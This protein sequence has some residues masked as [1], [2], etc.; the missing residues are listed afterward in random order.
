M[1]FGTTLVYKPETGIAFLKYPFL[2]TFNGEIF[3]IKTQISIQ[4]ISYSNIDTKAVCSEF[5]YSYITK[6]DEV[7]YQKAIDLGATLP[8]NFK[9]HLTYV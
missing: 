7:D 2:A 6:K 8:L 4:S 3:Q 5:L 1:T 9:A